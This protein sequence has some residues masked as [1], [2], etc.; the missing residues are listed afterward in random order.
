M[1]LKLADIY[2]YR[3]IESVQIY[4]EPQFK[5]LVGINESGKTNILNALSLLTANSS[6][7]KSDIRVLLPGEKPIDD[8]YV[9][10]I[11]DLENKEKAEIYR[12]FKN[13]VL[14]G[15]IN[16]L[17]LKKGKQSIS[18][19]D[20]CYSR[21]NFLYEVNIKNNERSSRYWALSQDYDVSGVWKKTKKGQEHPLSKYAII[22]QKKIDDSSSEKFEDITPEDINDVIG[23][24]VLENYSESLPKV[25]FWKYKE[26]NI[27]P[28]QISLENF[29]NNPNTCIPLKNMFL[30][31][32]INNIKE[33]LNIAKSGE[34]H[35]L[36]NVLNRVAYQTT[37]YIRKAWKDY[38]DIQI[39][40]EPNGPNID[41]AI[42]EINRF[43]FEQRSEGCKRFLTFLLMISSECDTKNI[44]N[45]LLIIDEP[46]N[47]LHPSGQRNIRD[48]L[49]KISKNNYVVIATHS[50]FIIDGK[51]IERHY[52]V[53]KDGEKTLVSIPKEDK[54]FEEEVLF[55]AVGFSVYEFLKERNLV[56][57]GW[58]DKKLFKIAIK[59]LPPGFK[60]LA[61]EFNKFGISHIFGVKDALNIAPIF[62]LA[63]KKYLF[64]SDND[65]PAREKQKDF[66]KNK[67]YGYWKR[68][69]EI[70]RDCKAI[71]GED[72]IK[73]KLIKEA[74]K[75]QKKKRQ[76]LN[77]KLKIDNNKGTIYSIKEW[78][79]KNGISEKSQIKAIIEE[80]KDYIFDNLTPED[81]EKSYF[82]FLKK[83]SEKLKSL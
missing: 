14:T 73:S 16:N 21:S 51:R 60:K 76:N 75:E 11:F 81:I 53:I 59:N 28:R 13:R 48:E 68:Y 83:L 18:I 71:T 7:N 63:G 52:R 77:K 65:K 39:I 41:I 66:R 32:G 33:E 8:A 61:K 57:E 69:N 64:V 10:F 50:I 72:F 6:I 56:F 79:G 24:L 45:C 29:L 30:I 1:K 37:K 34:G 27:L 23:K 49:K 38:K 36:R 70:D 31:A 67:C 55:N 47:G 4:F 2:N 80:I 26:A 25:I 5:I 35:E 3:S 40:L 19:K 42:K 20:F 22:D 58:R 82:D 15:N 74:I 43:A 9:R 54:L 62:E 78:L 44:E 46:E 17:E 12:E